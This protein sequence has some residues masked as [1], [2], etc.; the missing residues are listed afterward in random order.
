MEKYQ[1]T[2]LSFKERAKDLV[3]R[4]TLEEKISQMVHD[5][6]AIDRLGIVAHNWWSECLHGVARAGTATV[7]PQAIALAATFDEKL[8]FEAACMISDEARAK[9]HELARH[10]DRGIYKGLTYW[11]PNINIFRDPR[12]G[13]GHETYGE[14]PYLTARLGVAFIKGLQGNHE[15]YLKVV[16]TAKHFAVHSGPEADRHEFD[17]VVS[18]RDMAETYLPA[19]KAAVQEGKVAS[20]MGAYNRTNGQPCCGSPTLLGDILRGELGF[21][22]YVTSDCWAI[23]DFHLY[24][25]VTH[26]PTESSALAVNSG[27]DTNCGEMF[28]NLLSAV[29][30]G[31]ITEEIITRSVERLFEARMRLG[32]FDP[33]EAVPYASISYDCVDC[34]KHRAF[35][36]SVARKGLVLLKNKDGLL[37]LDKNIR[38]IAVIGPNAESREILLGNYTGTPSHFVTINEGIRAAVSPDTRV[39]YSAGCHLYKNRVEF[40]AHE[41]DRL[42]E[43]MAAAKR[44][45]VIILC[46]GLDATI[47]GEEQEEAGGFM[48]G[49]KADLTYPGRQQ[50]LLE[51][52]ASLGKP[53]VLISA[54]GSAMDLSFADKCGH[55]AAVLQAFYPGADGGRAIA[56]VL[57]GDVS[58]SGRLPVTFYRSIEDVPDFHD[59]AMD[60][61]TYKYMKAEA[62]YPFGFGLSYTRFGYGN[63]RLD[64][65]ALRAGEE[66]TVTVDITNTGAMAGDE[67]AQLYLKD[68]EASVRVPRYALAGMARVSLQPRETA[69]VSF[70]IKPEQMAVI[71]DDGALFIEDGSFTV[72]VGGFQPDARSAAL[73]GEKALSASFAVTGGPLAIR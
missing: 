56:D 71:G 69:T 72:Y 18:K 14:D 48:G 38:S 44:A 60:N 23:K 52:L 55:V 1:D 27:C 20:I 53:I 46:L 68:E 35:A 58:P 2:S 28:L 65:D 9:H 42:A 25:K 10:G 64:K 37:P 3:S 11:S 50:H 6:P 32:M 19:F 7:F 36:L 16:A 66:L 49:D 34:D 45:D 51:T 22:G 31:H 8:L 54:T 12:W 61:R 39:Y 29:A 21:D 70:T 62:L 4:M 43:A 17:A 59:Y 15:K 63:L 67:V 13:R 24:H 40:L 33:P 57:F 26:T 47:E 30:E 5:S 73:T 41:D